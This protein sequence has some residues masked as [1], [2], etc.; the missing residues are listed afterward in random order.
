MIVYIKLGPSTGIDA[1]NFSFS[2]DIDYNFILQSG[3]SR[4]ILVSV[5]YTL[6]NVQEGA[7]MIRIQSN[8]A[9]CTTVVYFPI[10][11][12][13]APTPT[14]TPTLT[15]TPTS[16]PTLTPTFGSTPEPTQTPTVT[17]TLT[18]TSTPTP[19]PTPTPEPTQT[20]TPTPTIAP[21]IYIGF[22]E[23]T[24]LLNLGD[25][26]DNLI[27]ITISGSSKAIQS[28]INCDYPPPAYCNLDFYIETEYITAYVSE[29]S[30]TI[31]NKDTMSQETDS[32][33]FTNV[34]S[35]NVSNISVS[36]NYESNYCGDAWGQADLIITNITKTSGSGT[37]LIHPTNGTFT[38]Q[39]D[40]V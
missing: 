36:I 1:D 34:S 2:S 22:D 15:G 10:G 28:W 29:T 23:V 7:T 8:T 40:I 33:T 31:D 24:G 3:I 5:G 11:G 6:V 30:A 9:S 21:T 16:T 32:W 18:P 27:D 38:T 26:Q 37:V 14:L 13:P 19:T 25:L 20:P 39:N 12:L 17:P 4:A 35:S